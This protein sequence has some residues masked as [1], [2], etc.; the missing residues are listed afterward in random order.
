MDIYKITNIPKLR[1][2]QYRLLHNSIITNAHLFRWKMLSNNLCSFCQEEKETTIHLLCECTIVE[3]L[4]KKLSVYFNDR[5]LLDEI[6]LST[7][8]ILLNRISDRI[9][10]VN[11]LCLVTKQYIYRQRCLK[12]DLNI[13]ELLSIFN[14]IENMEK[15]IAVKNNNLVKHSKKWLLQ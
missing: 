12:Q 4:W 3:N 11:F 1:S 14:S 9:H 2:F 7:S 15:Y 10:P 8:N 6:S 5:W 13:N